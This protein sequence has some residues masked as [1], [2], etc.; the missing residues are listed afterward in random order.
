MNVFTDN[1]L[2]NSIGIVKGEIKD[3]FPVAVTRRNLEKEPTASATISP[4]PSQSLKEM[5]IR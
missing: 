5:C 3:Q 4:L 2:H 1:S